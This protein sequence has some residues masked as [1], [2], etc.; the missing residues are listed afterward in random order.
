MVVK[1]PKKY[2]N[3]FEKDLARLR[4][5]ID[6]KMLTE[7]DVRR[8]I[9][10]HILQQKREPL[11]TTLE[12]KSVISKEQHTSLKLLSISKLPKLLKVMS[13][14]QDLAIGNL[15]IRGKILCREE[16]EGALEVIKSLQKIDISCTWWKLAQETELVSTEILNVVLQRTA[17]P[18]PEIRTQQRMVFSIRKALPTPIK[19]CIGIL[20]VCLISLTCFL[21]VYFVSSPNLPEKTQTVYQQPYDRAIAKF[22]PPQKV[23]VAKESNHRKVKIQKSALKKKEVVAWGGVYISRDHWNALVKHYEPHTLQMNKTFSFKN[24]SVTRQEQ[25]L[26]GSIFFSSPYVPKELDVYMLIRVTDIQGN[27][28]VEQRQQLCKG[29]LKVNISDF[30]AHVVPSLYYIEIILIPELQ[31]KITSQLF[32]L[33]KN[34]KWRMLLQIGSNEEIEKY[35]KIFAR[36]ILETISYIEKPEKNKAVLGQLLKKWKKLKNKYIPFP[37]TVVLRK[38]NKLLSIKDSR[39]ISFY[40]THM[41]N[42][43]IIDDQKSPLKYVTKINLD[44]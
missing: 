5:A 41:Q 22:K 28:F 38:L 1:L 17:A 8:A 35:N 20:I 15:L 34:Q 10:I 30:M 2:K 14:K 27:V 36:K 18:Q 39:K 7:K 40:R 12:R 21:F 4:I 24:V 32:A 23:V 11:L 3:P 44:F 19:I 42:L 6:E 43:L 31:K 33:K 16:V 29:K 13:R 37:H 26:H 25:D 9:Y